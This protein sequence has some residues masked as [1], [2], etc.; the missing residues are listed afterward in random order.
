MKKIVKHPFKPVYDRNSKILFLGSIASIKS[1]EIGFPYSSPQN[2]FW[3]ILEIL[4]EEKITDYKQFL[5]SKNI[6]LWDVIK[7]CEI[8]GSSDAS[9]KNVVVNEIWELID[10]SNIKIVFTNGKKAYELYNKYIYHKT[11]IKA[12]CLPSTSPA[13]AKKDLKSLVEEYKIILKYL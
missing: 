11:K 10:S 6:A 9:I 5:L 4:F 13:N 8:K 2:R 7:Q 3:K 1:R 12:I